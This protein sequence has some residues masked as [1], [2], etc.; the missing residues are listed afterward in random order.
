[1]PEPGRPGD[2]TITT[3]PGAHGVSV[4]A[5]G[6]YVFVTTISDNSVSIVDTESQSVAETMLVGDGSN[7]IVYGQ[8][9]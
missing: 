5:H 1:M 4:P 8:S 9:N 2:E 6:A 7:G 3:G